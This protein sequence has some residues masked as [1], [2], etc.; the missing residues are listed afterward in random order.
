MATTHETEHGGGGGHP[1]FMQYVVI[2]I[3]LFAISS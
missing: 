3:L 2:A 1:T